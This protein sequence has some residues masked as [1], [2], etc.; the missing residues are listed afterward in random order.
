MNL[1]RERAGRFPLE[2]RHDGLEQ[3]R[4]GATQDRIPPFAVVRSYPVC[5]RYGLLWVWMGDLGRA[6]ECDVFQIDNHDNPQW[7]ISRCDSLSVACHYLWLV[8]N[9][10][11]PSHVAWVHRSSFA[12]AGTDKTPLQ[13]TDDNQ[14]VTSSR[15]LLNQP[16]PPYYAPLVK[17]RGNADRLQHYEVR[18]PALAINKGVYTPA[19]KGGT[20]MPEQPDAYVMVSYHFLTPVDD[21]HTMYFWLQHRNTDPHDEAITQRNAAGAKAAFEEDRA[22]LEAVH[23]G[24]KNYATRGTGLLLDAAATRFRNGLAQRIAKESGDQQAPGSGSL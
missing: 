12:G 10:L 17:F 18:Y 8:D 15:W 11:D 6:P 4:V 9:L 5:E 16:P 23:M 14:G 3:Y 21:N 19:G 22:I 1:V 13:I 7:H 24:M 2:H 20:G